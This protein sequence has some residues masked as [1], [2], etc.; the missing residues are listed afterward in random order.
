MSPFFHCGS[1]GQKNS[2]FPK[3]GLV[4]SEFVQDW[5][6]EHGDHAKR[7]GKRIIYVYATYNDQP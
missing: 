3:G 5:K 2:F 7:T 1:A 4:K 6:R